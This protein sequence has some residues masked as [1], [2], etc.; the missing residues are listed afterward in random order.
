[1]TALPPVTCERWKIKWVVKMSILDIGSVIFG[2][3]NAQI[4]WFQNKHLHSQLV[5]FVAPVCQSK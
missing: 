4:T 1:M 2:D 5:Q 3:I